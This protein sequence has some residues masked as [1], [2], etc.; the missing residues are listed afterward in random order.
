MIGCTEPTAWGLPGSY[1]GPPFLVPEGE[2]VLAFSVTADWR[3]NAGANPDLFRGACERIASGGRGAFMISPGDISP[4]EGS[5]ETIRTY[6][7]PDYLWYPVIGNHETENQVYMDWFR[8]YCP[9]LPDIVRGGPVGCEETTYSFDQAGIHFVILNEFFDGSTDAGDVGD[10]SDPLHNWLVEDLT[11]TEKSLILVFGHVPAFPQP[12]AESGRIRHEFDSLNLFPEHRDR[13]WQTLSHFGVAAYLCGHTHNFSAV[14]ID[15][16]WQLDTGH[17]RGLAD[18]GA[19]ST[20]FMGYVMGNGSLWFYVYRLEY[21][22]KEYVLT[23]T[24]QVR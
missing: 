9:E 14:Q 19:R 11:A 18:T 20:F 12:D 7:A 5:L 8:Q 10:V 1:G 24:L 23:Q 3:Y 17:A 4:P 22:S 6:I 15:G 16:V 21:E 2:I 13:F